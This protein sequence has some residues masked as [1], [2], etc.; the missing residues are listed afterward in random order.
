MPDAKA[1]EK[2]IVLQIEH[3]EIR[4]L[5]LNRPPANALSPELISALTR[6]VEAAQQD[7]A[8]AL[9]LSGRPGMFSAGL[10]IPLLLTLNRSDIAVLWRDF[11]E[12]LHILSASPVPIVAAI[13]G[14]AP[15]GGTVLTLFC[16]WRI[17]AEGNWKIGLNEVQVGL[18][19]PPVIYLA[20]RRL[21]GSRQ[22]ERL[23]VRGLLLTPAEAVAV[24]LVDE[25]VAVEQVVP[26]AIKWCQE[27]LSLPRTSMTIT[28]QQARA[29]LVALFERDLNRELDMVI[30]NWCDQETQ[31]ALRVVAE[32]LKKK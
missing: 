10:D 3:G 24:G 12:L 1:R 9:V 15:A 23:A 21:V 26:S 31:Y 4:E 25:L 5:Q 6:S 13:T 8:R 27:M 2:A 20:L 11:Y 32:R 16:D 29:D 28:R 14:H 7:G 19:L 17:A 22:A 30:A 18:Q